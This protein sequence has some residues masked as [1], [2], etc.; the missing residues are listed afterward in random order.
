MSKRITIVLDDSNNKILRNRQALAIQTSGGSVS[1]SSQ[2][3]KD[4]S[5]YFR[6]I[7]A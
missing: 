1:F 2:I 6:S 3:N 5:A 7:K 4:L